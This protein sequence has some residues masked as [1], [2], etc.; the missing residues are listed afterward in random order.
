MFYTLFSCL[1]NTVAF[2]HDATSVHFT[3]FVLGRQDNLD[4]SALLMAFQNT[5]DV[6]FNNC[7]YGNLDDSF[8][9]S[10][11]ASHQNT[12]GL[13]QFNVPRLYFER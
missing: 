8:M 4:Q 11:L 5:L 2:I 10:S 7:L 9:P 6:T 1:N 12:K 3:N 13:G